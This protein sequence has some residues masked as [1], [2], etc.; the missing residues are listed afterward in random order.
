M[1]PTAIFINASRGPVVDSEALIRA[2]EG[3]KIWG[4]GL[5]VFEGEPALP[6]ALVKLRNV[7]LTPHIASSSIA[8]RTR[9]AVVAAE[10]VAALFQG[11]R[12]EH[13]LNPEVLDG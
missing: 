1:K 11:K 10:N 9:M 12:P 13:V 7:V 5:D 2:L 6:S 4:A 8:T 3:G